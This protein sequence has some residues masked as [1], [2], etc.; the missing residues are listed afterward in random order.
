MLVSR[1]IRH[2][3]RKFR[4]VPCGYRMF[5]STTLRSH[6]LFTFR[7]DH[8]VHG[9]IRGDDAVEEFLAMLAVQLLMLF[10]E[11]VMSFLSQSHNPATT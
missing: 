6:R 4:E 2:K 9:R 10:A 8:L 3:S 7:A 1:W 5:A 11:R